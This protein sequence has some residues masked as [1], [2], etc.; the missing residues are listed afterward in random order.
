LPYCLRFARGVI[1]GCIDN[2]NVFFV[3]FF[4]YLEIFGWLAMRPFYFVLPKVF[5]CLI[6]RQKDG[7]EVGDSRR[8]YLGS[9]SDGLAELV[10]RSARVSD[11]GLYSCLAQN[12]SGRTRCSA[13][14]R[15]KG[16]KNN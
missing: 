3:F 2:H 12:T 16:S 8:I 1:P 7:V 15:V 9:D 5:F 10:I 6:Y 14:L 4:N 11:S 13:S